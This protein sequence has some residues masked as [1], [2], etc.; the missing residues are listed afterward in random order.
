MTTVASTVAAGAETPVELSN[1]KRKQDLLKQVSKLGEEASLGRDS[2][3]KLA[4]AVVKAVADGVIDINEKDAKGND[5][6]MQIFER[7]AASEKKK[8][9]HE[10][11][12][13]GIKA[14]VSKLRQ[15]MQMAAMTT[16][17]AVEVMNDAYEAREAMIADDLKVKAAYAFYIDVARKQLAT[18]KRLTKTEL[19]RLAVKD[20][21]QPKELEQILTQA[22][23]L[24]EGLVTGENRD[25]V[26][27]EDEL[28]EAAMHA[29]KERL[30]KLA[31]MKRTVALRQ[32][33]SALGLTLA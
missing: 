33:A 19:E 12:T 27:D 2:L 17:D 13:Q 10:R 9:I 1:D 11:S 25:K 6:A 3:P 8:S 16:I 22:F 7:Y 23:K 20:A 29:V 21:A 18:D 24:L 4:H 30:D 26:K 5:A 32:Q 15:I 31:I 28:T 14:N